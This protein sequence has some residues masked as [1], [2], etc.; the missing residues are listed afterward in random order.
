MHVHENEDY[1]WSETESF[2]CDLR[3]QL[4]K[5]KETP[6][7]TINKKYLETELSPQ[8]LISVLRNKY[9]I[10]KVRC[11][12]RTIGGQPGY[13]EPGI[14]THILTIEEFIERFLRS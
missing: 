7:F 9:G 1:Y 6:G 2:G 13:K 11:S 14:T 8:E 10:T 5:F 4:S 12:W 3:K